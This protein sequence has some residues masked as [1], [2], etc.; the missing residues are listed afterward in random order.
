[1]LLSVPSQLGYSALGALILGES[2][3]LPLPGETAL[4]AAGGL[5]AAGQLSL[6]LVILVATAAA[7]IGDT[8]GYLLGRRGGRAFLLRDGFGAAHR[9]HAVA[10]ADV[11]FARY[12]LAAVFLGR[13]VPV[14]RVVVALFAGAARM[15]WRYFGPA[16]AAGALAWATT[17][18]TLAWLLGPSGSALLAMAGLVVGAVVLAIGWLRHRRS[19]R[20][21]GW[22]APAAAPPGPSR[23]GPT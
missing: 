21:S 8:A 16:N 14:V 3:G 6:P 7:V 23:R 18:A 11:F 17:V 2:A 20:P 10:R 22:R 13:W 15:P 1:M 9:R 4:I 19:G 12:G 5:V